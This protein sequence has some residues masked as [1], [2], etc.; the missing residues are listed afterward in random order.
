M[1]T[2]PEQAGEYAVMAID[3]PWDV[4]K[5][6][7]RKARPNQDTMLVYQ[8]MSLE[9]IGAVPIDEWGAENS[10]IFLWVTNGKDKRT[11]TPIIAAGFQLLAKWGYIYYTMLT[12]DKGT[13]VCPYGPYQIT[14]EHVLVGY[15]GKF[16]FVGPLG[17]LKT[18]FQAPATRHSAKPPV[19]YENTATV[20]STP[21]I[22][23]FAREVRP[24]WDGWGDQYEGNAPQPE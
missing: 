9:E 4:R 18:V 10:I 2:A 15:R 5:T 12:W 7:K 19:F 8:T 6:G 23:I 13:G 14:S 21:R 11:K 24:G 16:P 17:K 3:P 1:L 22:E 20:T